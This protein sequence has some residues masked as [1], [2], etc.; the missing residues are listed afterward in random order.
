L[1]L[2]EVHL[3]RERRLMINDIKAVDDTREKEDYRTVVML[4]FAEILFAKIIH[5]ESVMLMRSF[6]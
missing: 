6:F 4:E 3:D 1:L 2:K 5:E